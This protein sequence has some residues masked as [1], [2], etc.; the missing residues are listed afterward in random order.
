MMFNNGSQS[1]VNY[2]IE[3]FK[4]GALMIYKQKSPILIDKDFD[5]FII[6]FLVKMQKTIVP[7]PPLRL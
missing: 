4:S 2:S 3:L 6:L 7:A 1:G 5:L